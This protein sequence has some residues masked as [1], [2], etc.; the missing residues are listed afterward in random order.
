MA[1]GADFEREICREL[2]LW[3]S[4]GKSDDWFWRASQSGGRATVRFRQGKTTHGHHGDIAATHPLGHALIELITFELKVGY[5]SALPGDFLDKV[6]YPELWDFVKQAKRAQKAAKT[7]WWAVIH[8]RT[9]K[10]ACIYFPIGLY[11]DLGITGMD[12][13]CRIVYNLGFTTFVG[14]RLEDFLRNVKADSVRAII[15]K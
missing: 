11:Q 14:M 5:D 7:R 4:K 6:G 2:S 1:K 15:G 10:H 13:S 8:R 9:R 12:W 3:F